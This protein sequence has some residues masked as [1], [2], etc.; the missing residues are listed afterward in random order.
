MYNNS[1]LLPPANIV[2]LEP[3]SNP[4]NDNQCFD[5]DKTLNILNEIIAEK[6]IVYLS[7]EQ[8]IISARIFNIL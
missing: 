8:T 5:P 7:S 4:N 3:G 6:K 1:N 2:I